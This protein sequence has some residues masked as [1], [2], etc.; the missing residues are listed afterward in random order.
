MSLSVVPQHSQISHCFSISSLSKWYPFNISYSCMLFFS[1]TTSLHL[2]RSLPYRLH[3][4]NRCSAGSTFP[5]QQ[6]LCNP[7]APSYRQTSSSYHQS[8]CSNNTSICKTLI[9]W[10]SFHLYIIEKYGS[11]IGTVYI[12][13]FQ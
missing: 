13:V 10:T 6:Q 9:P 7:F 8:Y 11:H 4:N 12:R 5:H 1:L 2:L 3:S